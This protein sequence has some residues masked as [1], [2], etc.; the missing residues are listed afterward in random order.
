MSR[1]RSPDGEVSVI[2][3]VDCRDPALRTLLM[4]LRSRL[5]PPSRRPDAAI[6]VTDNAAG[7][8]TSTIVVVDPRKPGANGLVSTAIHEDCLG[9]AVTIDRLEQDLPA[10]VDAVSAG[11]RA[12]SPGLFA[13]LDRA[14]S[15]SPRQEQVLRLVAL[16]LPNSAVALRL[17]I[18]RST[19][20]REVS[21][22]MAFFSCT[23]RAQL[24]ARAVEQG[25]LRSPAHRAHT[26]GQ[27]H[28]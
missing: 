16:G 14:A 7:C 24:S 22:L 13:E 9:G 26:P 5:S 28:D 12:F 10:V 18:S 19:V 17:R 11:L 3:R 27:D 1:D 20:K 21:Q 6:V 2:L 8:T 25:F 4:H 23:N 15:P